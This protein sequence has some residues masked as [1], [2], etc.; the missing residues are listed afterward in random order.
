MEEQTFNEWLVEKGH[1]TEISQ[2]IYELSAGEVDQL[3]NIWAEE[4]GNEW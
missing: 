3:Y 2:I 1:V 4:T